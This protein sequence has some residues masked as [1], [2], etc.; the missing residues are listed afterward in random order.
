MGKEFDVVVVG[1]RCAGSPLAALLAR[2]GLSVALVEQA[3]FPRDTLSTHTFQ[4]AA[5]A[6]LGR[7]GALDALRAT[8]APVVNHL[9]LRQEEFRARMPWPCR[10]GDAGG[11]LSVRRFLLDP[12]LMEAAL[13][14]GAEV[15]MGAKVTALVRDRGRVTGVRVVRDGSEQ[16]LEARLVVGADGRNSTVARLAGARKYNLTPNERF[17]YWSFFAGADPGADPTVILH[18]WSGTFVTALPA[19]SGLYLVLALPGLSELP[20]FRQRLEESYLEYIGRCDPVARALSGARRVGKIFGMLRWEGFFREATG[21]GWVLAGDAG[22]F[23]DPSPGQGIQDAFRQVESLAPAI[24]GAIGTSPSALDEALAGWARW[25]DRDAHEYYWL[26]ADFGKAGVPP[27]VGQ[28][29]AQRLY[30]QGKMDSFLDLFNHR[31]APSQVLTLP[32]VAGATARLL[33]RRG[34]DRR[35]LLGEVGALAAEDIRRKRLARHPRYVPRETPVHAA[36]PAQGEDDDA[37]V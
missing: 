34:C 21:P 37:G 7:L 9:D 29:I 15:W 22:H 13:E 16:G 26:A 19:D 28:E 1:G 11:V 14:A 5:I 6:F 24:V 4:S 31:S 2:A 27:A 33:A 8:E 12:I 35:A 20:R 10:P 30:E 17:M 18:R 36:G 32:R 25:R 23:K 3:T